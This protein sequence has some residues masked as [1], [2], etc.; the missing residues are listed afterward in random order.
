MIKKEFH[1]S[2][3]AER[4]QLL[5]PCMMK[6]FFVD[7]NLRTMS[8]TMYDGALFNWHFL[9]IYKVSSSVFL[10]SSLCF[11]GGAGR[12]GSK[13]TGPS[14]RHWFTQA[15]SCPARLFITTSTDCHLFLSQLEHTYSRISWP[16]WMLTS[17][18]G[19]V[20]VCDTM[21]HFTGPVHKLSRLRRGMNQLF[22]KS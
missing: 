7:N 21:S 14:C 4:W 5:I 10:I 1:F 22:S 3:S 9:F 17:R 12:H 16:A 20:E 13:L 19:Q 8:W 2:V 6:L 15:P 18:A 11:A